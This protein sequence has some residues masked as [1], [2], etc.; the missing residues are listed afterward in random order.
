MPWP[1]PDG[2]GW[3]NLHWKLTVIGQD[4]KPRPTWRGQ[5][6][7]TAE[8]LVAQ[9]QWLAMHADKGEDVYFCLSVQAQADTIT[10]KNKRQLT[11][12]LRDA[13]NAT[14]LKAIWLDVD[15]KEPPKGYTDLK[16]GKRAIMDFCQ[17]R[18]LPLP[19]A[20]VESGGGIHPYWI[21]DRPLTVEE[22]RPFAEGLKAEAQAWGLR[23][24]LGVTADCARILRMPGTYNRKIKDQPRPVKVAALGCDYNFDVDLA[25]LKTIGA[26]KVTAPV[27]KKAALALDLTDFYKATPTRAMHPLLAADPTIKYQ[28][29]SGQGRFTGVDTWSDLP[30]KLDN[31]V[32]ECPHFAD[33]GIT[34]GAKHPQGLWALTLLAC[35]FFEDGERWAHYFSK[36]Y[37]S[38][39]RA[40]TQA[41]YEEKLAYKAQKGLGWPSCQSFENEGCK[42]CATCKW[43]GQIGSPL[44]LADR[45]SAPV[46]HQQPVPAAVV[47][48][49][50]QAVMTKEDLRLPDEYH[51]N[52][53]GQI[54]YMASDPKDKEAPPLAKPVFDGQIISKPKVLKTAPPKFYCKY[55]EGENYME[56]TFEYPAMST[57]QKMMDA[58]LGCGVH[59][60]L[61][62]DKEV[63]PFMRSF[64]SRIDQAVKRLQSA[65]LGWVRDGDQEKGKL[66][67][68]AY[69]GTL[70]NLDGTE[71]E[72]GQAE[73]NVTKHSGPCGSAEPI[74]EAMKMISEEGTPELE[75]LTLQAW[76]SPLLEIAG[77]RSTS[78]MWATSPS[79]SRKSSALQTG[80]ALWYAPVTLRERGGATV[81]GLENKM[82]MLRNLPCV[83]DEMTD[84]PE[85]DTVYPIFN[86]IH[87]GG[88]GSRGNKYGGNREAKTWQLI[89][90]CGSNKSLY[91]YF[92]TK[93]VETDAKAQRVFELHVPYKEGKR[94]RTE[95]DQLIGSLEHNYGH[96]G[97]AYAQYVTKNYD[98]LRDMYRVLADQVEIELAVPGTQT[99][100]ASERFWKASVVLT[101][102]ACEIANTITGRNYFHYDQI[103]TCLYDNVRRNRRWVEQK[104]VIAGS[105]VHT[106][107][108]WGAIMRLWI[109]NQLATDTMH[110]GG[111]R[112]K[113]TMAV[114]VYSQPPAN[115]NFPVHI[116]WLQNP[117]MVRIAYQPLIDAVNT[118]QLG[119]GVVEKL[120]RDFAGK[121]ERMTFLPGLPVKDAKSRIKV[122][123]IPITA[124]HPLYDEW[125]DKVRVDIIPDEM[126][127]ACIAQ[128]AAVSVTVTE[129][130]STGVAD[131]LAVGLARTGGLAQAAKDA[132]K[133]KAST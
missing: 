101:L 102:M 71:D 28:Q 48:P 7:K 15:V 125:A 120:E 40:E 72:S 77:L 32:R 19:S 57:D 30:L 63:R 10:L 87:E 21:S 67:G 95:A 124:G 89:L 130:A 105:A 103:K 59:V 132:A 8:K 82:D 43:K 18:G 64:T 9:A 22:W 106:S 93:K 108:A 114:T 13:N 75:I 115:G 51:L 90:A 68:F 25:N 78:I 42:L 1:G 79:G 29:E 84:I 54:C 100:K 14:L 27:T 126:S 69:A 62:A 23:C 5:P 2:P 66:V 34:Q 41:K 4:G 58:I 96:L 56:L 88:Q 39:D 50:T 65:P 109:N 81:I 44:K 123:E 117:P 3:V 99:M 116:H 97:V 37:P 129:K 111:G 121:S 20:L 11:V 94:N 24:D 26:T 46:E 61:G 119:L 73:N 12:A 128:D 16:E 52:S 98:R 76:A 131:A 107:E 133:I 118:L 36:G 6:F 33:C 35:S 83:L 127:A 104:V 55:R 70:Y 91:E 113:Q 60:A 31:V 112:P 85:I 92:A 86:R 45:A 38:Y 110:T 80:C 74:F 53:D 122:W 49:Q 17:A 47:N